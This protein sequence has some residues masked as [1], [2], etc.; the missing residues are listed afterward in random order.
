MDVWRLRIPDARKFSCH[1]RTYDSLPRI[2]MAL[3]TPN[4]LP[5]IRNVTYT[6]QVLPD[7]TLLCLALRLGSLPSFHLWRLS[8]LWLSTPDSQCALL[9]APFYNEGVGGSNIF[10]SC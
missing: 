5:N 6:S 2:D 3:V 4:L 8:P 10:L 1:S 7:H 9:E